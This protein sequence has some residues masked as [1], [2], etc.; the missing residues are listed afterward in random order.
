MPQTTP[1]RQTD[2]SKEQPSRRTLRRGA[3]TGAA[4]AAATTLRPPFVHA[5]ENNTLKVGLVG[6]KS[7][8][9]RDHF[10]LSFE[11]RR[12]GLR[13]ACRYV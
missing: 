2:V 7:P 8:A 9:G 3:A 4:I 11:V 12:Q 1:S 10:G 5:A 13:R 6:N